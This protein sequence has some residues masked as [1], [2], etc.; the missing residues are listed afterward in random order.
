MTDLQANNRLNNRDFLVVG[1][2]QSIQQFDWTQL[3]ERL[4]VIATN[5]AWM[6]LPDVVDM[7]V[8]SD[9]HWAVYNKQH[10][11][12]PHYTTDVWATKHSLHTV[13]GSWTN[14]TTGALGVV[15]AANFDPKNIFCIGFDILSHDSNERYH[16][17]EIKTRMIGN[18]PRFQMDFNQAVEYALPSWT[19]IL[20]TQKQ[21]QKYLYK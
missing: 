5:G 1:N 8:E 20:P 14:L 2:G 19:R 3:D 9:E 13:P 11:V 17:H 4:C 21:W 16:D 12:L 10:C 15:L 6:S 18:L 7:V